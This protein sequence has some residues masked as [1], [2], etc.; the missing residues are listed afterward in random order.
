MSIWFLK[1]HDYFQAEITSSQEKKELK[2]TSLYGSC[3][4][5]AS[6]VL[7]EKEK[8][9]CGNVKR[10]IRTWEKQKEEKKSEVKR[11]KKRKKAEEKEITQRGSLPCD[12]N[13]I[14]V[15]PFP[16]PPTLSC[17]KGGG[18]KSR[19]QAGI[20]QA[21]L[22]RAAVMFRSCYGLMAPAGVWSC[23]LDY[24][25]DYVADLFYC[26]GSCMRAG[27]ACGMNR[28][29]AGRAAFLPRRVIGCVLIQGMWSSSSCGRAGRRSCLRSQLR[30]RRRVIRGVRYD[31]PD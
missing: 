20:T 17:R 10:E 4:H 18:V 9:N 25:S 29:E 13:P 8:W 15:N 6:H 30:G 23:G 27:H 14:I 1:W 7:V 26:P 28:T 16:P 24:R 2:I 5:V 11:K 19:R 31:F 3:W 12:Q 22:L 21:C